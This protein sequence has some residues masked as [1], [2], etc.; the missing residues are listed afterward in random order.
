MALVI[1]KA[2]IEDRARILDLF[3][4][5]FGAPADAADFAW[6]YDSNPCSAASVV[7]LDGERAIGFYGALATRYRSRGEE[8]PG[9]SAVG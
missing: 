8:R 3:E 9:L 5:A 2:G 7:A 6:K 1:Q 4:R